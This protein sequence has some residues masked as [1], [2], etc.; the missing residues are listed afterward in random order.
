MVDIMGVEHV[1]IGT[2]F[3]GDGGVPGV[4]SASELINFTRRLLAERYSANDIELIWGANFLR[5]MKLVQTH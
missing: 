2:D 5:V 1:G 3:D 4:A